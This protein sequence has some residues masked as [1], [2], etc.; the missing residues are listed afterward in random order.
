[1]VLSEAGV[2]CRHEEAR[3]GS[4]PAA[5]P[6]FAK[7]PPDKEPAMTHADLTKLG[8]PT[9]N[10]YRA[11]VCNIGPAE[12]ARRRWAGH[13]GLAATIALA[14]GLLVIGAPPPVR[15]LV[16]L[17][18]AGAASGYLQAFLHFCAGFGSRGMYNF[19]TLGS[20]RSVEDPADRVRDM[21]MSARIAIGSV[22]IGAVVGVVAALL[23][24]R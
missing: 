9:Q 13:I 8:T 11:G 6:T 10:D 4:T 16:A 3:P 15:L 18:A 2:G 20:G 19:G 7:P 17:P 14:A 22:A 23:P 5:L 24:I 1:V 21:L 12:I